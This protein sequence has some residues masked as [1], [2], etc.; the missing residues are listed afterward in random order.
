VTVLAVDVG[1]SHASCAAVEDN[2]V[3]AS[4]SFS[5][6]DSR[7]FRD[8]LPALAGLLHKLMSDVGKCRG[9]AFS[10][11][12]IVDP[13]SGRIL[14]TPKGKYDDAKELDLA[15]WSAREFDLPFAIEND[16]RMA[17]LGEWHAGA[18][19]GCDD[20]VMV[21]LGTGVGGAAMISGR[22]LRGRH[23]QAGC[24]GGHL[25]AKFDG[26]P[27]VC[28]AIGCVEA[29]ASGW[30]LP[31]ICRTWPGFEGS[32]LA[33]SPALTF[34]T[35]FAKAREGDRVAS[36]IRDQCLQVWGAGLVGLVHAYDPEM[37]VVGGAV[38]GS[39]DQILPALRERVAT[40]SWTPWGTVK[41]VPASLGNRAALLGAIPLLARKC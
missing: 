5:I 37:I 20:L 1:G 22:L 28:G 27:C 36:E 15:A 17:L 40:Y 26:R 3:L 33:D 14:S 13:E 18:A 7:R 6:P 41:V 29:E 8:V 32:L 16:A 23:L 2:Q 25:P 10:F 19:R 39:A 34:V 24:M 21:T 30:A 9:L 4:D 35:L 38:M 12:G 31:E 11:C